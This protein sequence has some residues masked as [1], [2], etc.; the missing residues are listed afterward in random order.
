MVARIQIGGFTDE[1][2]DRAQYLTS[3]TGDI[4]AAA[5]RSRLPRLLTHDRALIPRAYLKLRPHSVS[6]SIYGKLC[7]LH[8]GDDEVLY[9]RIR[10][11]GFTR[12]EGVIGL[13]IDTEIENPSR[14]YETPATQ[15]LPQLARTLCTHFSVPRDDGGFWD[16]DPSLPQGRV[17]QQTPRP[18]LDMVSAAIWEAGWDM[19]IAPLKTVHNAGQ[20]DETITY[21]SRIEAVQRYTD[22]G[23]NTPVKLHPLTW[24]FRGDDGRSQVNSLTLGQ[25]RQ[26]ENT[27][28]KDQYG[29][30]PQR[31]SLSFVSPSTASQ[32]VWAAVYLN[33]FKEVQTYLDATFAGY[34]K[35]GDRFVAQFLLD[36][37]MGIAPEDG[38]GDVYQVRAA[39]YDLVAGTSK[40]TA[41]KVLD[42]TDPTE[43]ITPTWT[44]GGVQSVAQTC[45]LAATT[46]VKDDLPAL[47]D[48]DVG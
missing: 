35:P 8:M 42:V 27:A 25:D 7:L 20:S 30:L 46:A 18:V 24:R 6:S 34:M 2:T 3:D 39:V 15:S 14:T 43:G 16:L 17:N 12:S 32:G 40:V 47:P 33:R 22:K 37:P 13:K 1:V 11:G 23:T 19:R 21:S 41:V 5:V 36:D 9:G 26:Y 31:F 4:I 45:Y 44:G 10:P 28:S 48:E 29:I 38:D